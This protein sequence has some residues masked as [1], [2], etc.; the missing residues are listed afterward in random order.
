MVSFASVSKHS[1]RAKPVI[2][3]S[4][5]PTGS[6]SWKSNSFSHERFCTK[7]RF[8]TE[9]QANSEMNIYKKLKRLRR[10][11]GTCY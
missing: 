10:L 3:K 4:V 2:W 5:P 11:R 7:T 1:L 8:E 9:A 6:F